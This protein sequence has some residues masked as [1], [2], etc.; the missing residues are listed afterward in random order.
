[1][2]ADVLPGDFF[3]RLEGLRDGTMGQRDALTHRA[4]RSNRA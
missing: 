2:T 4:D 1:M 3:N